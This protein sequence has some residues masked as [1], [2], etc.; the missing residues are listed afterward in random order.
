MRPVAVI[1][2]TRDLAADDVIRRIADKGYP[3]VPP[4]RLNV[5]R[6]SQLFP[7][8]NCPKTHPTSELYHGGV[9]PNNVV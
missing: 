8:G 5:D 4:I 9:S 2:N 3:V 6:P 7:P 1:T